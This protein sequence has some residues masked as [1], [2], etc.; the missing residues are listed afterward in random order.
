MLDSFKQVEGHKNS[1]QREQ[2]RPKAVKTASP[3]YSGRARPKDGDQR[4]PI[5]FFEIQKS[6][7]GTELKSFN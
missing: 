6:F 5:W 4:E 3:D 2:D 7:P 1:D